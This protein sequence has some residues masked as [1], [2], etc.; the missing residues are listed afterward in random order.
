MKLLPAF[1]LILLFFPGV[2]GASDVKTVSPT[3]FNDQIAINEALEAV[4]QAGGG[5]VYLNAG[6]YFVTNTVVIWS[7]T[8]LTGDPGAIIKVSPSSS[9]WFT[10]STGIIS[11][12][13]SVKRVEI[14]GFSIDGNCGALPASFA[15]TPG[16]EKDCERCIILGGYSNDVAQYIY[17]HDM[18]LY[19]SFSDG[20]YLKYSTN[21][22]LY[23]N[24]ISNCQHEGIYLSV[25]LDSEIFDNKIGGITSDCARLDNCLRIKVYNNLFFSYRGANLNGA[26][27]GGE[28]GLQVGD[29]GSSHGY[30]ASK[31]PTT[32]TDI[33]VWNNTFAANGL[34]A[35]LLGSAALQAS[36]NV[37]IHD[38]IFIGKEA[39]EQSGISFEINSQNP[40]TIERTENIF[41]SIFDVLKQ[42][43]SFSFFDQETPINA[44]VEVTDYNNTFNPHALVYI[45]SE[46]LK[47]VRYDYQGNITTHFYQVN[48]EKVELWEGS[49]QHSGN[50]VYL[51]GRFNSSN[52]EVTC[53]N[54]KGYHKITDFNV[55]V[56]ND[57]SSHVL[58]PQLFSFIG[59]LTLLGIFTYK[60]LRRIIK[61]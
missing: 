29:A 52:L 40:Q 19:N 48:N 38:N 45:S 43:F 37:W 30:D 1:L 23:R 54:E 28:N 7:N 6:V 13:E 26:Y 20:V 36:A 59:T 46:P 56:K 32:T 4:H 15:N 25:C 61:L 14:C 11:C 55:T 57:N 31:K 41:S 10:G 58:N 53:Y 50:A 17:I 18:K 47:S 16:H 44:S 24:T 42:D 49:L 33:E 51:P 39:L 12:K 8:K 9:Q 3:G 2:A 35:I 27:A 60:N 34:E 22:Y 21:A 5:E